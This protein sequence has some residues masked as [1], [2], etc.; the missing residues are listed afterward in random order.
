MIPPMENGGA[1]TCEG[2]SS[3]LCLLQGSA[4]AAAA[5][6]AI[7]R[8]Q[9]TDLQGELDAARE[10]ADKAKSQAAASQKRALE[11]SK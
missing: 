8:G 9:I 5:E 2:G 6:V 4:S 1:G 10:E 3:W 11:N 7:L